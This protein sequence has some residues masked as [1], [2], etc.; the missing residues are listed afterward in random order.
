MRSKVWLPLCAT[1]LA[2]N[3]FG[4]TLQYRLTDLGAATSGEMQHRFTY[5]LSDAILGPS[6]E[7]DIRFDPAVFR[8][9]S[10]P[11]APAGFSTL[12]LQPNNPPGAFGDYSALAVTG[13]SN[14]MDI[15]S[16]DFVLLHNNLAGS[17]PFFINQFDQLT[18][19]FVRTVQSG[20]TELAAP[21]GVPEPRSFWFAAIGLM[22]CCFWKYRQSA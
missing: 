1:L 2:G 14:S 7:I 6:Q 19:N 13:N 22:L 10:N 17:Q 18:G 12:V 20:S 9:L 15:F 16:V 3:I 8:L 21:A 11:T 4:V 5:F